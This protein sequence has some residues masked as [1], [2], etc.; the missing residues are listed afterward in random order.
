MNGWLRDPG[1]AIAVLGVL[2]SL[3]APARAADAPPTRIALV[4]ANDHYAN[5]RDSLPGARR[6]ARTVSDA[7]EDKRLG[8]HVIHV[9]NGTRAQMQAAVRE[10][11][12]A[13]KNAGP[14]GIGLLYYVG[15]GGS[16]AAGTDNFLLPVDVPDVATVDPATRG[17]GVRAITEQLE[18]L[19]RRP[20]I[21]IVVD[22]CRTPAGDAADRTRA[23]VPPEEQK[24]GFLVALSTSRGSAAS[25]SGPYAQVLARKLL[26]EGLTVDQVFQQVRQDVA[27]ETSQRQVPTEQS[28]IVDAV[29]LVSCTAA[30]SNGPYSQNP[31]LLES[32]RKAAEDSMRRVAGLAPETACPSGWRE[33]NALQASARDEA[34]KGHADVAGAT[35]AALVQKSDAVFEYLVTL[36][37]IDSAQ[38]TIRERNEKAQATYEADIRKDHERIAGKLHE[39][40]ASLDKFEANRPAH[41]DRSGVAA[42]V[43]EAD[44]LEAQ[45]RVPDSTDKLVDALNLTNALRDQ[46]QNYGSRTVDYPRRRR[47]LTSSL[48]FTEQQRKRLPHV[49]D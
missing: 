47:A 1:R 23:L 41:L 2:W 44:A 14:A 46:I 18:L 34:G 33:V 19:D 31:Q 24:P 26:T 15:H 7:L 13:L 16:D 20:A 5:P 40:T 8:F 36:G 27:R 39:A 32:T 35:Y 30:A 42:L 38:K 25:D 37:M 43:A 12:V 11:Q 48:D 28:K 21:M 3:L 6:D 10:F 29:C 22:A 49:C 17:I 9:D 45:G 4:I